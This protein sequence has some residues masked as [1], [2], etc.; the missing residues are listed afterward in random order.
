MKELN[1]EMIN[2]INENHERAIEE[3]R[4]R[5]AREARKLARRRKVRRQKIAL[6][7]VAVIIS[8]TVSTIISS[9]INK[10]D[11]SV[12]VTINVNTQE[13]LDK[14]SCTNNVVKENIVYELY[15][16][17]PSET[18]VSEY[19][20][21]KMNIST[22]E[23]LLFKQIVAAESLSSWS[24]DEILILASIIR[25][26]VE[27]SDFPNTINGV[28]TEKNQFETYSNGTYL[29]AEITPAVENAVERAINGDTNLSQNIKYFCTKDYYESIPVYDGNNYSKAYEFWHIS[30]SKITSVGNGSYETYIFVEK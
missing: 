5:D 26:R 15:T 24:E 28:L 20:Y 23:K 10:S 22:D 13:S 30:L 17:E 7:M 16:E 1:V 25:N 6:V 29:T 21:G 9:V 3:Q 2:I 8:A 11:D 4:I 27:S 19:T 18:S 14:V 12:S